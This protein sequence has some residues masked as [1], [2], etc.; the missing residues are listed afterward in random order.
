MSR[1]PSYRDACR[2]QPREVAG[3][4]L[5]AFT[6]GHALALR[7][8]GSPLLPDASDPDPD[9]W[10]GDLALALAV[11]EREFATANDRA[12]SKR[13]V[14]I[15]NRLTQR[16][17]KHSAEWWEAMLIAEFRDYLAESM[18]GPVFVVK[19]EHQSSRA[20]GADWLQ[21]LILDLMSAGYAHREVL[22]MPF[23]KAR[24]DWC[25]YWE[26]Q[27]RIEI[28]SAEDREFMEWADKVAA[29]AEKQ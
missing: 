28:E 23:G 4:G 22:E 21:G 13:T 7:Q 29:E 16:H 27:G 1:A 5:A 18:G 10:L 9:V 11:C 25:A 19:A 17:R 12:L 14:A 8:L 20:S 3:I 2:P 6:V 24:W 26:K 15:A